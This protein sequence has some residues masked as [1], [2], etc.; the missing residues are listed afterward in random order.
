[1][2]T[3]AKLRQALGID[4][5]LSVLTRAQAPADV[6]EVHLVRLAACL[7]SNGRMSL[8]D[9]GQALEVPAAAVREQLPLLA[10]RLAACGFGL[11]TDGLEV[12]LEP[13]NCCEPP[14]EALRTVTT[15][16]RRRTLSEE[17]VTVLT[18]VGWH[19]AVTRREVE[20][21]RGEESETL[22]GRFMDADLIAAVRDESQLGRPNRYRLTVPGLRTLGAASP[23]ELREKLQ[24]H[25]GALLG[26]NGDGHEVSLE[27][28]VIVLAA[29]AGF[30]EAD[31]PLVARALR[32]PADDCAAMLQRLV[33]TDLL[34]VTGA[35]TAPAT[36]S[37]P[38]ASRCSAVTG[39]SPCGG[40]RRMPARRCTRGSHRPRT[41]AHDQRRPRSSRRRD[42][43]RRGLRRDACTA[44]Q[45]VAR[46][47]NG[48]THDRAMAMAT[49]D[50]SGSWCAA[51][52]G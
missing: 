20:R 9:L 13:L 15:E 27:D 17:A 43:A 7:L 37:A 47:L 5:P 50:S 19:G 22:L 2:K 30:E 4:A 41:R 14:L 1:V 21:F 39:L 40:W 12:R 34:I 24:P 6:L 42:E 29:V 36:A 35:G 45:R 28:Q 33:A 49:P 44:L 10:S 38:P 25:L 52:A 26:A 51:A 46:R 3:W 31:L 23:E 11:L 8:P 16:R 48:G 18:Y 32:R